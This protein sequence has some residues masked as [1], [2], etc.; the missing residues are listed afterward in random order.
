[1]QLHLHALFAPGPG[2]QY[3]EPGNIARLETL[4]QAARAPPIARVADVLK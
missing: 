1:M 2:P 4:M 3:R